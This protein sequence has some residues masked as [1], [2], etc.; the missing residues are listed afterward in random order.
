MS[1]YTTTTLHTERMETKNLRK[2]KQAVRTKELLD[3][4]D[5]KS[6]RL[7]NKLCIL[8]DL[9][10][11]REEFETLLE[12]LRILLN[13]ESSARRK[14]KLKPAKSHSHRYSIQRI[15]LTPTPEQWGVATP[16][17]NFSSA[18]VVPIDG[19]GNCFY[20]SLAE[21][22]KRMGHAKY[23][24]RELRNIVVHEIDAN[25]SK[26][27][28]K[29]DYDEAKAR[30][31]ADPFGDEDNDAWARDIEIQILATFFKVCI[32]VYVDDPTAE[33]RWQNIGPPK[34]DNKIYMRNTGG[35]EDNERGVHFDLLV[36]LKRN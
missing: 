7:F 27:S 18:R 16:W 20:N 30:A 12:K 35:V 33:F 15:R 24:A 29:K 25:R 32:I 9:P 6:R 23:T 10:E 4:R 34:C 28:G 2:L 26:W 8:K 14:R 22:L 1:S 36:D 11:R 3:G 5:L 19:D 13:R 31:A 17:S 21:G